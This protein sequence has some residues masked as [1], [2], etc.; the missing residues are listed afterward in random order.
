M[1]EAQQKNQQ[2]IF[3]TKTGTLLLAHYQAFFADTPTRIF[4]SFWQHNAVNA[5]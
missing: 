2:L 3:V 5:E 1:V 4:E